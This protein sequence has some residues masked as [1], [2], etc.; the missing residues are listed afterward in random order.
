[1]VDVLL[2]S[3]AVTYRCQDVT[4]CVGTDPDVYPGGRNDECGNSLALGGI[5]DP[6]AFHVG[7]G[8]PAAALVPADAR[9]KIGDIVKH[10]RCSGP[11]PVAVR[12]RSLVELF[13]L[14]A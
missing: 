9:L 11:V 1:M 6:S 5:G 8:E 14:H 10:G 7:V 12:R 13:A 4:E 3:T 2:A